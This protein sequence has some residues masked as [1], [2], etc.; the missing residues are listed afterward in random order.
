MQRAACR[1][2]LLPSIPT[3]I[4]LLEG[5]VAGAVT[6]ESKASWLPR[7]CRTGASRL[8]QFWWITAAV[9]GAVAIGGGDPADEACCSS[10]DRAGISRACL[11]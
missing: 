8:V 1:S 11:L 5:E 3:T 6:E 7:F 9:A 2:L 10:A 4:G